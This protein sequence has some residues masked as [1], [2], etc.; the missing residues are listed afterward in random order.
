MFFYKIDPIE[1]KEPAEG[2]EM[3]II[4]GNKTTMVF[5]KIESG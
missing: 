3:R 2:V 1:S 5:F 4:H